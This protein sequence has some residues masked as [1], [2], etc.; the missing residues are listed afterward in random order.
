MSAVPKLRF[1]EFGGEWVRSRIDEI[2]TL[3]SGVGFPEK[4][5][6]G[7]EGTPFYKVSDMNIPENSQE[8]VLANNYV[9]EEQIKRLKYKPIASNSIIFAKVGAAIFLDRKRQARNFLLDNNMMAFLPSP[10]IDFRFIYQV[11]LQLNL[12][13]FAQV[14]A[15]PSYNASD[16]G[17]I[18][19]QIPSLPEQQKIAS[20][21]SSVDKKID[22][23]RQKKDALELYKK[24]LMQKIFSQ[25]IRFKQD[26][27]SDF[28]DWEEVALGDVVRIDSGFAFKSIKFKDRGANRVIRMSDLKDSEIA[29]TGGVYVEDYDVD[30]L[31]RF[32]LAEADF[33]FGM[34]GSL[35]NYGWIKKSDLPSYLNQRV[36]RISD[37]GKGN[38]LFFQYI[39][40]LPETQKL[41]EN[42]AVGAAQLNI[43]IDFLRN[44]TFPCPAYEEQNKIA[45]FLSALDAKIQNTSSQIDQM[46]TFKKGL[47]QQM[48]V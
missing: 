43:S 3:K 19:V 29:K 22:L 46:E 18:K 15:L 11:F 35:S 8:M 40:L 2:G 28:P 33:V 4:E 23:L 16:I 26:D 12:A 39:Y 32:K 25:E 17:I 30:G 9:T 41:I 44:M 47:L 14:G 13:K 48:F 27:G 21:L 31:E 24:G 20:F 7:L 45:E 34:S 6:G 42:S 1:P 5:Q 37:N 36:G 10:E 38:A